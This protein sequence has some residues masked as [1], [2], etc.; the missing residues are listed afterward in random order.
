VVAAYVIWYIV[1]GKTA[2][3]IVFL[4]LWM[5]ITFYPILKMPKFIIVAILSMV[6]AVLII[7]YELQVG[8]I[9]EGAATSNGQPAYPVYI[10]APYRLATVAGG[11]LVAVGSPSSLID[12][13]CADYTAV[14]LDHI[15]FPNL[16]EHGAA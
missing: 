9:G 7:G 4:W 10:L 16:R 8:V 2:G 3:A 15:P 11:I 14:Y 5:A 12:D 1:D 13:L 6:T